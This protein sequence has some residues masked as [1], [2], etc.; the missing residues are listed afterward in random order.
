[1]TAHSPAS[2]NQFEPDKKITRAEV[3]VN[4][5][6]MKQQALV[7][8]ND[9]LAYAMSLKKA[10]GRM[11]DNV[12]VNGNIATIP[13]GTLIPATIVT[14][15]NSQIDETGKIFAVKVTQN[16]VTKESYL[17]I[18]ACSN[19]SGEVIE[20][21]PGKY[22]IRNAKMTLNTQYIDTSFGQKADF[23]GNIN[24][25]DTKKRCFLCRIIHFIVKGRKINLQTGQ[26][27]YVQLDKPVS[28]DLTCTRI[29]K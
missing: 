20:V 16:L 22:F 5:Y 8:P 7:N 11:L 14:P 28:I 29:V 17:L 6:N 4:I 23:P 13:Q 12:T 25:N 10:S 15:L 21:K 3:V 19:I 9:K 24:T 18:P 2:N 1:M 26:E 27:V